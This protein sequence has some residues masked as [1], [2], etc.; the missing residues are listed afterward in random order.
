MLGNFKC[1]DAL[2]IWITVRQGPIVL[3]VGAG[4]L[5]GVFGHFSLAYLFFIPFWETARYRL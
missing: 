1:R 5:V 4:G 3:I 2:L